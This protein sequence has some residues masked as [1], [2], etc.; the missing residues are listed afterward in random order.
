MK[1]TRLGIWLSAGLIVIL[2]LAS[3][4]CPAKALQ[5]PQP[6]IVQAVMFWLESC[7]HCQYVMEE[8]LPPLQAQYGEQLEVFMIQLVTTEDID[9]LYQTAAAF[10]IAKEDVGV[11]FLVIG[12]QVLSGS[13]QIAD[14]LPGLIEQYLAQGGVA[15]PDLPSLA[16]VLPGTEGFVEP[17]VTAGAPPSQDEESLTHALSSENPENAKPIA[18][19]FGLAGLVLLGMVA[20]LIFAGITLSRRISALPHIFS[21]RW[22][23][24]VFLLLCLAGLGVAGYLAYVETQW[25]DALCGP[26][27]DCNAVQSSPYARLFGFLPLG[28]LGMIGYLAI[29]AGWLYPRLRRD[30]WALYAPLVVLG[31]TVFG[32]LFSLYLTYLELFVIRAV[33]MWCLA[34][35]VIMTLL[36]L[37][38]LKPALGVIQALKD[39]GD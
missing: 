33:C 7:G 21:M 3:L 6:P 17:V 13:R 32:V 38:S 20:A 4:A 29:L 28:V 36:L 27:G 10:G 9:R 19:G 1:T 14:E 26:V 22:A 30:R 16:G 34:S 18:N 24:P 23:E 8:V 37:L 39:A 12:D 31:M 2:L 5:E 25:V 15:Y 11:P 35:A